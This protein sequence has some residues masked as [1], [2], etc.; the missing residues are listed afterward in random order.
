MRN[1]A[2]PTRLARCL[3]LASTLAL[4]LLVTSCSL[5]Q[6]YPLSEMAPEINKTLSDGTFVITPG[7]Q[8][9]I[10]FRLETEWN[11]E[12]PVLPDGTAVFRGIGSLRVANFS[13]ADL[14]S[15]L[16]QEYREKV[17]LDDELVVA[18]VEYAPRTVTVLGEVEAPGEI[19]LGLDQNLTL[20]QAI[21]QAGSFAKNSAWLSSTLLLR[22]DAERQ[23]MIYWEIDARPQH[24]TGEEPVFLQHSDVIYIPNT[25]IDRVGI[26]VDNFIRR[27][28]PLPIGVAPGT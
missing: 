21:G 18:I 27:M 22:W 23:R 13:P 28:L 10:T 14:R 2:A 4:G 12:V 1:L 25:R 15:L 6:G 20:V 5:A 3:A 8:L 7:D 26:F 17:N 16:R 19:P 9:S 11:D 24:W